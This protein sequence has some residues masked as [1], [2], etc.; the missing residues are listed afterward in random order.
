MT[1]SDPKV[2]QAT[3]NLHNGISKAFFGVAKDILN[4]SAA[5]DPSK[6]MFNGYP[7]LGDKLVEKLVSRGEV[8]TSGLFLG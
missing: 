1:M 2:M 8:L 3:G 6:D 7:D 5:F 4:N